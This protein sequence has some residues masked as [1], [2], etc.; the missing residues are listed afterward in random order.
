MYA[1]KVFTSEII[2]KAAKRLPFAALH[3]KMNQ[4][5]NSLNTPTRSR[6]MGL[7]FFIAL[8]NGT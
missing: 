3:C 8:L 6:S 2:K 7:S 1:T 5:D 4:M